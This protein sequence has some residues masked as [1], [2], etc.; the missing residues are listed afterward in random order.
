[1]VWLGVLG[2][3]IAAGWSRCSHFVPKS[4]FV[5]HGART[6]FLTLSTLSA[7]ETVYG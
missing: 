2:S 7:S 1:M 3:I 6:T 4:V 5:T